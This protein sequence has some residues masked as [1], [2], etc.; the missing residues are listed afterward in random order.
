MTQVEKAPERPNGSSAVMLT[1]AGLAAAFGVASCC[2]LPLF[3]SGAGFGVAW[4]VGIATFAEPLRGMLIAAAAVCLVGGGV[5]L[6]RQ[7]PAVCAPGAIC[8]RPPVRALTVVGLLAG[9][10]LLY[11]GYVYV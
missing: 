4:L 5:L 2:A 9:A 1:F 7:R 10:V 3:L 8:A 11:L 6:W